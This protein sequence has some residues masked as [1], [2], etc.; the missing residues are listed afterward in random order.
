VHIDQTGLTAYLG[1]IAELSDPSGRDEVARLQ[2]R[3]EA[4]VV[5]VLLVGEAKRGKS[6]LGNALLGREV[7]PSGVRP[8]TAITT[9]ITQGSPERI[10]VRFQ[11]GRDHDRPLDELAA[12]VTE[13]GNPANTRG[14]AAVTVFL[15][16]MPVS[17]AVLVDTPGVG[18]VLAHN[19]E[20]AHQAMDAMDVAVFVLTADPPI[21]GSERELLELTRAHAVRTF[22]VLNKADRLSPAELAEARDFVAEVTDVPDVLVCSARTGLDARLAGDQLDFAASGVGSLLD[23]LKS[24]LEQRAG[25]DL[26]ESIARACARVVDATTGRLRMTRA[27]LDAVSQDRH[28]DVELFSEALHRA[29]NSDRQVLAAAA[30]ETRA[31]RSRLDDDAASQVSAMTR[32]MLATLDRLLSEDSAPLAVLEAYLREHVTGLIAAEVD[33]WRRRWF[34]DLGDTVAT[35]RSHEQ[36]NLDRAAD[37]V[38]D[39]ARRLLGTTVRP[40]IAPLEVP[41]VRGFSFDFSPEVGWNTAVAEQVRHHLPARLRRG[42]I[43][44]HL[45]REVASLVDK[46]VGR[47]R[48]D[49]QQRLE[50]AQRQLTTEVT[51]RFR[52]ERDGLT[53]ALEAATSLAGLTSEEYDTRAVQLDRR[54]ATLAGIR[55]ALSETTDA[56][57]ED[58]QMRRVR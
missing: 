58:R 55:E 54:L 37:A 8:V 42:A 16:E 6:T 39:A 40:L 53:A 45:R 22:V 23:A 27:A 3:L 12:Y 19:T 36:E 38:E 21:S 13:K 7:L 25:Q 35:L 57:I 29:T 11:D 33:D 18:S 5:R 47:A 9:T 49:L 46:Q 24:R 28:R 2:E 52:Q 34:A 14:V 51:A 31:F 15:A 48:S 20:E 32:R 56:D 10:S 30:W 41:D 43:A 17:G 44:T 4:M 50:A 1:Q 26:V